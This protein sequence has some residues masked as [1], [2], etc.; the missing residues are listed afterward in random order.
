MADSLHTFSGNR[1]LQLE[2]PL[3]FE[4]GRPGRLGVDL[5]HFG[6]ASV[7]LDGGIANVTEKVEAWFDASLAD[8]PAA[9]SAKGSIADLRLG[10][11]S[12]GPVPDAVALA[13]AD[14][15]LGIV[16]GGGTV[17]I[18]ENASLA[19]SAAF[20]ARLLSEA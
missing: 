14:L 19:E 12:S 8:A 7:Q 2:E 1:G 5:D 20:R 15:A 4:Q 16:A 3:I 17:V 13:F 10:L 11:A 9:R 18:P 6:W